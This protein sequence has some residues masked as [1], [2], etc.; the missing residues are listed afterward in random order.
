MLNTE[1]GEIS[2]V[3]SIYFEIRLNSVQ[4]VKESDSSEFYI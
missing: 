2:S 3:L 1:E 4:Y